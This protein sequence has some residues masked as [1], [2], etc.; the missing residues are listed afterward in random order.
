ME[1]TGK[2]SLDFLSNKIEDTNKQIKDHFDS[3]AKLKNDLF[4]FEVIAGQLEKYYSENESIVKGLSKINSQKKE[5]WAK[6]A[7]D[8]LR[9]TNSLLKT[10]DIL[11]KIRPELESETRASIIDRYKLVCHGR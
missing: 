3:I 5:N 1:D 4:F 9:K 6:P 11:Y 10:E 7:Y 8:L 2:K